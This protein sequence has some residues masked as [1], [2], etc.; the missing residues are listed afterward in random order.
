MCG[1]NGIISRSENIHL[2]DALKKMNSVIN[3]RGPDDSG[4]Y[5]DNDNRIG[6]G[7][8]RLSIIDLDHG[9]QPMFNDTQ[10][11]AIVFNGEIYNF[12]DLKSDLEKLGV[13]FKT[14]SDTEVI[15]RLFEKFGVES[16][17]LLDGMFAFS[18]YDIKAQ[19]IYIARDRFGEKPLYYYT[20]EQS[21][22]WGSELKSILAVMREE[23][24][25]NLKALSL[26]FQLTY[27]PAPYTIY[28]NIHKLSPAT[29]LEITLDAISI[30]TKRYVSENTQLQT[31]EI[32]YEEAKRSVR[33]LVYKS[34]ESRM[35]SDVPIGVFLSGGVDSGIVASCMSKISNKSVDSFSISFSDKKY[36]ESARA[37]RMAN[38][39]G[40]THHEIQIEYADLIKDI[41]KII[42]NY[43]EP[44]A[45]SS[46]LPTYVVSKFAST[47]VKVVLTGDGGDEMFAGYNKYLPLMYRSKIRKYIPKQLVEAT[48]DNRAVKNLFYGRSNKSLAIK[49]YKF[50][51]S[52]GG[53]FIQNHIN[54]I[55][56]GFR[57]NEIKEILS[58]Y[59]MDYINTISRRLH[60]EY[61]KFSG[62]E[63]K[64]A[65][66][67]DREI[68]LEGDLLVK[69]DRASMLASIECRS[70]FLNS[71]ILN[72]CEGLSD[73]FFIR[74]N[75]KKHILKDAFV[76]MFPENYLINTK[77]GFE[78]PLANFFRNELAEEFRAMLNDKKITNIRLVNIDF[79]Q[80][81]INEHLSGKFDHSWRLW[82]IFCFF[83]WYKHNF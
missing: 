24:Q 46:C 67:I 6:I 26:Y 27:I 19:K 49:M 45:D 3:H 53:D 70:P 17:K 60:D 57:Q 81:L 28:Q 23:K 5:I 22:I 4:V 50:I 48:V 15:L 43:D 52:M 8:A 10:S 44:Y 66:L 61:E 72:F 69:V 47:K 58:A 65:Q 2:S 79:Y 77:S 63:L 56:L 20:S 40:A 13:L 59:D 9:H 30:K 62:S 34:V 39:I 64:F 51:E 78:I 29:Y 21:I 38:H 31:K 7:M 11:L 75:S 25:I 55:S 33:E 37:R 73:N 82:V 36:N 18:I 76:D 41:D 32:S 74:K 68:S 42:L 80:N 14:N 71:A 12:L 16:F 83:K 54:L 35:I 1:I